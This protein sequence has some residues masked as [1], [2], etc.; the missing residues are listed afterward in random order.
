MHEC[1]RNTSWSAYEV[2]GE[3]NIKANLLQTFYLFFLEFQFVFEAFLSR[4]AIAK[5]NVYTDNVRKKKKIISD[6]EKQQ[7]DKITNYLTFW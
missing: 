4:K 7:K 2:H 3:R 6:D 1:T 5:K